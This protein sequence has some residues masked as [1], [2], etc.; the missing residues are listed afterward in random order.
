MS[1]DLIVFLIFL[2]L[3]AAF[4]NGDFAITI[5]YLFI[6][7]FLLGH[8][9]VQHSSKVIQYERIVESHAF[10][11]ENI[12]VRIKITNPTILPVPWLRIYESMPVDLVAG[13][14]VKQVVSLN[15]HGRVELEYILH[16]RK[17]GYYPIGPLFVSLGDMLGL[18]DIQNGKA[19]TDYL[20]VYPRII[21]LTKVYLPSHSPL[22][23]L[24]LNQPIFDD[25]SRV[26]SKRDYISGD[27]LR[28]IDW[29]ASAVS[30][31][32]QVKQFESS[33]ELEVVLFLNMNSSDYSQRVRIDSQELAVII[34]ASLANWVTSKKQ[35]VGLVTNGVSLLEEPVIQPILPHKGRAHL[36]R[37]LEVLAQVQGSESN[38][39]TSMLQ[40]LGSKLS[41]GTTIVII[42]GQI[43]DALFNEVFETR[44]RGQSVVLIVAG[45]ASNVPAMKRRAE[46]FDLPFFAFQDEDDLDIW[47]H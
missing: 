27:S 21:P 13:K 31:Q 17:R 8:L 3:V 26:M 19:K 10:W 20:T 39:I 6:G 7:A 46:Y 24:R 37:I 40:T 4:V 38:S 22:G 12:P 41:W 32:L 14:P 5:A 1:G 25:P 23:T 42:T 35:S 29:K 43:D 33:I 34:A 18:V 44:R 30:G 28:R 11:G 9:W 15:P 47:R 36:M 45:R 2:L 16:A